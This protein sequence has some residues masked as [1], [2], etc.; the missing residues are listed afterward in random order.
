SQLDLIEK[1]V[2]ALDVPLHDQR[3]MHPYRLGHIQASQA[4]NIISQLL[5]INAT[6][7]G[8]ITESTSGSRSRQ[9]NS[10]PT[11]SIDKPQ[12]VMLDSVN[13]LLINATLQ[14]HQR[15]EMIL[16]HADAVPE[17]QRLLKSYPVRHLEAL[18]VMT[19][20]HELD[21]LNT[22]APDMVN[23]ISASPRPSGT[24][25]RRPGAGDIESTDLGPKIS[26]LE[27]TNALLVF[28]TEFQHTR[29]ERLLAH[30]DV[31]TQDIA[32]PYEIYFLENQPPEHM[33]ETLQKIIQ[34]T[35]TDPEGKIQQ[36]LQKPEDKIVIVPDEPTS[37]LIVYANRQNQDWINK[38][39]K[40]LDRRRPQVL[41][42]V[43]L[44]EIRKTDEFS[45]DL[46]LIT[47]IP[48]LIETSG[49]IG[50]FVSGGQTV[51]ENL[52]SGNR[53]SFTE[54][55][56]NSGVGSGF[57]GDSHINVLLTA[58]QSK[59]YGRIL[60]KPK[61][62]V[63]DNET[64]TI[65]TTEMTYVS[66]KSSIPVSSGGAGNNTT[67]IETAVEYQS[68]DAGITLEI[69]PHASEGDLLR[70]DIILTRSDFGTITGETPPDISSSD[71]TTNVT[72]PDAST[73][74]LGGMLRLNQT[75][76]GKK[77]PILGDLP[78]IGAL[79][80]GASNKDIQNKLY[81]FVRAEIIRPEETLRAGRD[82][83]ERLSDQD[84]AAFE[85]HEKD[86]QDYKTLP[87]KRNERLDP[88]NVLEMK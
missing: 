30:I 73:I 74:I 64:G 13:T 45:Y 1:L 24:P 27:A 41:I 49:Q 23:H 55:Q 65:K 47:A 21:L 7:S 54:F 6:E 14:Q 87:M 57:Y 84:R 67:L 19:T 58:M 56:T 39:I 72:V 44:V 52:Q 53:T 18:Q 82:A 10:S 20:L 31:P 63:N 5:E 48:D 29:L 59:N 33:A 80:R 9:D 16:M 36:V 32:I 34:E 81:I 4:M 69:T 88:E 8:R 28:A 60:A 3:Q 71:L 17:E 35:V 68:Y 46:N 43:T 42:D 61:I 12:I 76:A 62:L 2:T 26:I 40:T 66:T 25:S 83:L 86:F 11:V 50:S 38:L 78:L 22:S 79:F 37:S 75:K 51:P 85:Q 70:L 15:I 77:V